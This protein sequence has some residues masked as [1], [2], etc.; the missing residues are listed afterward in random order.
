MERFR[1]SQSRQQSV[2]RVL[3]LAL[4]FEIA[5][6]DRG[7]NAPPSW[8]VS[9]RL[10]QLIGGPLATRQQNRDG[11]AVLYDLRKQATH[12]GSLMAKHK[13]P[14]DQVL[15]ESFGLPSLSKSIELE[16]SNG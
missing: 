13:K 1:L 12:G 16:P 9:V 8:K 14:I 5:I 11:V 6:S 7:D 3:D 4:A 15:E 10:A 2:D